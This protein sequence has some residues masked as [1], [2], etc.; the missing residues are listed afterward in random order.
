MKANVR[1]DDDISERWYDEGRTSFFYDAINSQVLDAT[2]KQ[3]LGEFFAEQM[4]KNLR[5]WFERRT[6]HFDLIQGEQ[7]AGQPEGA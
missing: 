1:F 6:P 3:Q 5:K 2:S 7:D 4:R